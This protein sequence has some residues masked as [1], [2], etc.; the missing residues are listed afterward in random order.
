MA[1]GPTSALR[2]GCWS[3][4][5][6]VQGLSAQ[7]PWQQ[8]PTKTLTPALRKAAWVNL[9][10]AQLVKNFGGFGRNWTTERAGQ[11]CVVP[12]MSHPSIKHTCSK[13]QYAA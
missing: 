11:L 3:W 5:C 6:L 12:R 7:G 1:A 2:W 4:L 8:P 10:S 9:L 13:G